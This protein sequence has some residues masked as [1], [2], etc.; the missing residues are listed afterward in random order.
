V[1]VARVPVPGTGTSTPGIGAPAVGADNEHVA[2]ALLPLIVVLSLILLGVVQ[3]REDRN[4]LATL[5]WEGWQ[6]FGGLVVLVLFAAH[7]A[8]LVSLVVAFLLAVAVLARRL[9][10]QRH[11]DEWF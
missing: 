9:L 6:L 5:R 8:Q 1:S 4:G 2:A 10:A 11:V 7:V 3:G